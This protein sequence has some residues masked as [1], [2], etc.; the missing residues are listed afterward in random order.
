[1]V[2][3]CERAVVKQAPVSIG[4]VTVMIPVGDEMTTHVIEDVAEGTSLETVMR[5]IEGADI[6]LTGSGTTALVTSIGGLTNSGGEGWTYRV[7]GQWADR[8][9]GTFA[10][11]PPTTVE[12]KHGEFS[13]M[14]P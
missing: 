11:T 6:E 12:W 7:D 4:T 1:M 13:E 2:A 8:G 14:E 3:G 10:L 9:I 5:K